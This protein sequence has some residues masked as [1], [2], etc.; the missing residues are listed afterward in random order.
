MY[1]GLLIN[2]FS[3]YVLFPQFRPRVVLKL[4]RCIETHK[5]VLSEHCV[6]PNRSFAVGHRLFSALAQLPVGAF[7]LSL[8]GNRTRQLPICRLLQSTLSFC[9]L[10][11]FYRLTNWW[12]SGHT[13]RL[14]LAC[15]QTPR[16]LCQLVAFLDTCRVQ[17]LPTSLLRCRPCFRFV[18]PASELAQVSCMIPCTPLVSY[19]HM[20]VAESCFSSMFQFLL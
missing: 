13:S 12:S 8:T 7:Q 11:V 10:A 3:L 15:P 1:Q 19:K 18:G 6:S 2:L 20:L 4:K 17:P 16:R 5:R 9:G 14:G